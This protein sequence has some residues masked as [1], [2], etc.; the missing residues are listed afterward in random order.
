MPTIILT[1]ITL[2]NLKPQP[3]RRI[4]YLDK[5]LK[6][7]GVRITETGQKSYVLTFGANRQR[8]KLGDVGILKLSDARTKARKILAERQ[9]GVHADFTASSYQDALEGFLE[10]AE[11]RCKPRTYRDYRRLLTRHGF[12]QEKLDD[13]SPKDI[14]AKLDKLP[15]AEKAHAYAALQIFFR[16]CVRKYL[17]QRNPMERTERPRNGKS[18]DRFLS[19]DELKAVWGASTGM[20]GDI[21]KLC[22]LTGQRRSEIAQLQWDWVKGDLITFP[23]DV[24]KNKREHSFP[25][26]PLAQAIIEREIRRNDS[27]YLF[28]ARKTWRQKSSIYNA[29]GKDKPALDKMSGVTGWVIHDLRRTLVSN[30]AKLGIRQEVT[31]KYINHVSGTFGGIVGVYQ[32]HT[33]LDEMRAAIALWEKHLC[34]LLRRSKAA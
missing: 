26:G 13:I 3:G 18:R 29:W 9:L 27:P 19:D 31:E 7:F 12:G 10:A 11:A 16:S 14:E 8:V 21:I 5:G 4:T 24:T 22:I 34:L 20:F 25:V 32:R 15:P 17:L 1:D 2:R 33:Y 28:P 30:W 23:S 6:G